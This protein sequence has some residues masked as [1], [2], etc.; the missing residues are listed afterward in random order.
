[1]FESDN[2]DG[3]FTGSGELDLGSDLGG[4]F[5][6]FSAFADDEF[7]EKS[8]IDTNV[9][10][11]QA[12]EASSDS[13]QPQEAEKLHPAEAEPETAAV[14]D[15][16]KTELEEPENE[17]NI[18]TPQNAAEQN[19][20]EKVSIKESEAV[21]NPFET[22]IAKAEEKQA[23]TAKS[24][25]SDKLPVFSY[26]GATEDIVDTSKTFDA[27]RI[28]KA[29]DFPELDDATVVTWKMV[30]GTITKN[31]P[32]PKKTSVASLKK[33]IEDSKEFLDSLKKAKGEIKCQV[34]PS[35]TAKKKGIM[36]PYKG[37]FGSVDDAVASGK[38]IAFVPSNNGRVYEVRSNR[39]GTFIAEAD[40]VS[41]L[42]K[43]RAGFVPA[44]PKIPYSILAEIITFF[45]A[46]VTTAEELEAMAYIYWSFADEK[47]Y[48]HVPKQ[49]VSK[50]SVDAMLPE[51]DEDK[52]LLVMEIHSHNTMRA[53]FSPTDDMDE[54]ATRLYTVVGRLDK[55]FPD[56]VTRISV[57][58]KYVEINPTSI[59][60]GI[61]NPY[62]ENWREAVEECT[63]N[64]KEASL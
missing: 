48:V 9:G 35:V 8:P 38:V 22:A 60:D 20:D 47:Y 44:L 49:Q 34:T 36:S 59:F 5:A 58:G 13:N 33:Q 18:S 3:L 16:S 7:N 43:V 15:T 63:P 56:I 29:E 45:K 19:A 61:D 1:M 57:G 17:T 26:A 54:R 14:I 23:E 21:L 32:T 25:L 4:D 31:I 37:V 2:K 46:Y 52:F 50:A 24:S 62:P 42:K 53:V 30:Y 40:N 27:L 55:L 12:P 64:A 11:T 41:I 28:E 39:I 6:D 10:D 51:M